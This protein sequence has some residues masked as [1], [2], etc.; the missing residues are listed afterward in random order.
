MKLTN[1]LA[2]FKPKEIK[3]E[4]FFAIE[5]S[6]DT[7]KSAVWSVI[8]G[9]TKIKTIGPTKSWDGQ[10]QEK[11]TKEVDESIS[12]ASLNLTPEP[13]GVIFGLP[14]SWMDKDNINSD[15]KNYLK[16]VCESLALKPLGFVVTNTAVV[17]YLKIEEGSPPSAIFLQL[18]STEINLSLVKLG[19][20]IGNEIVG[21]S[22][23]LGPDVEE[24]LSRFQQVDTLPSRMILYDGQSDFEEDRQQL[25][26]YDWE[27]K[28]PFIHFP[29]V[30]SLSAEVSIKAIA[31]SGGS[32]VA[33]SLGFDI[34][35]TPKKVPEPAV[36]E[37]FGFSTKDVAQIQTEPM[38]ETK[39]QSEVDPPAAKT[40]LLQLIKQKI[41]VIKWPKIKI[42]GLK[43][44]IIGFTIL[45]ALI[46]SAYWFLPQAN[47]TLYFEP[48]TIQES[49]NITLDTKASTPDPLKK[50]L[51]AE[52]LEINVEGNK[53][54]ASTGKK[55]TGTNA[56]GDITIYN[57][58]NQAKTFNQGTIL[59]AP[60]KL[61]FSLDEDTTV[62]SQS[63]QLE[64][65]TFG[66]AT[67]KI[68]AKNIGADSNLANDTQLTFKQFSDT[69]YSAK[70]SGLSGGTSQEVRA[71][72]EPDQDQLLQN[73][74][75]ELISRAQT[76]LQDRLGNE[77][78]AITI[79]DQSKLV[80]KTF[81]H[82]VGEEADN[83]TLSAKLNYSALSYSQA[84]L[85]SLLNQ[86][87]K[88]KIPADFQLSDSSETSLSASKLAAD[89]TAAVTTV[90]FKAKLIPRLDLELL[91]KQI[92]GRYPFATQTLF[93]SLPSFL[94]A[95]IIIKPNLPKALKTLPHLTKNIFIDLKTE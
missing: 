20:I 1:L 56:S 84:D 36:V 90:D 77:K 8:D 65:T 30:E 73:L 81:N 51:P 18:S 29:K 45:L 5:I 48:K 63:A 11:L 78:R 85:F 15:K 94:R 23:D 40:P 87:I 25:I 24:G 41:S 82:S 58:T 43:L 95:D 32:E 91:K 68:T 59:I 38:P 75:D 80:S 74:T 69:D 31:L 19:K 12:F 27:E 64:G 60:N 49:F 34:K 44:I 22:G 7:I 70:T 53:S 93:N 50:I 62:A 76:E 6:D 42:P 2:K 72:S 52:N 10:D 71:V 83:L 57:K 92:K 14:E 39:P 13:S 61:T 47:L 9:Q 21:R 89:N 66:K 35:E 54:T 67:A 79:K 88:E 33:K 3:E 55:L 86:V 17:Q 26:S 28:L 4:Y 16:G 37:D 46:F